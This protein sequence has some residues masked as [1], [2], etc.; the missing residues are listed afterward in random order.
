MG[1]PADVLPGIAPVQLVLA[2]NARAAVYVSHC[3]VYSTGLELEV[4]VLFAP[5]TED[6]DPSLNG[7]H[8]RRDRSARSD[9]EE[10]LKFGVA[11]SDGRKATN[12]R[13]HSPSTD[14]PSE[15]LLRPMG[16]GGGGGRWHQDFW[17]WPLPP[18][19]PVAFVCEWPAAGIALSRAEIDAQ[20][21]LD[22]AGRAV[23]VFPDAPRSAGS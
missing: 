14:E 22:A 19:G 9:F 7:P 17:V 4:R 1:P 18:A 15:P 5:G 13:L 10:M 20:Q 2:S 3:A 11:F 21:L 16:G 12:V 23:A 6:L 8:H